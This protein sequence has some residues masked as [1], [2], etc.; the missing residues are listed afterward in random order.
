V[1][2]PVAFPGG[3]VAHERSDIIL[4]SSQLLFHGTALR[5]ENNEN[6]PGC[7]SISFASIR[8]QSK[9]HALELIKRSVGATG[10]EPFHVDMHHA[11]LLEE[12]ERQL[13]ADRTLINGRRTHC[14]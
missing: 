7:C 10:P 8:L 13:H 14:S 2:P 3:N 11:P 12:R 5:D 6:M 1:A 4:T 9:H